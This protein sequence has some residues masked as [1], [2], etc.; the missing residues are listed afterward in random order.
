MNRIL[1]A[2]SAVFLPML[3]VAAP[4]IT[5]PVDVNVTNPV[6]P[7][8]VSNSYPIPVSVQPPAAVVRGQ[9]YGSFDTAFSPVIFTVPAGKRRIVTD[10][11]TST[12]SSQDLNPWKVVILNECVEGGD[13][14]VL[15]AW[16]PSI[17]YQLKI[18]QSSEHFTTGFVLNAGDCLKVFAAPTGT[19]NSVTVQWYEENVN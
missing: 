2:L 10:I 14:E 3:S 8:E 5:E 16:F 15:G 12:A 1:V 11:L 18:F 6:L 9:W 19:R 13:S 4:P 17:T 7:V